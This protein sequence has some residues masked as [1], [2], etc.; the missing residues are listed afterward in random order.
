MKNITSYFKEIQAFSFVTG[1]V[2]SVLV[3]LVLFNI[4]VPTR[5]R[6][7]MFNQQI[8]KNQSEKGLMYGNNKS[9]TTANHQMMMTN[10]PYT[11]TKITSEKQFLKEMMLHHESAIIMAQQALLIK[12]IRPEVKALANNIISAQTT[13]IR[14]MKDWIAAWKY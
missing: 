6:A 8:E 2:S 13:E 1:A 4:L 5:Y 14:M 12:G 3:C 10:N 7:S 11:M 9:D